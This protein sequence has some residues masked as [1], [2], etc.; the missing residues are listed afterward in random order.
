[1]VMTLGI[2]A[3]IEDYF[4]HWALLLTRKVVVDAGDTGGYC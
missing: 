2:V 1:M 4:L 3:D